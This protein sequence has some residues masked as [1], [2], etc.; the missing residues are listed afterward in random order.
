MQTTLIY[1]CNR[2]SKKKELQL[3]FMKAAEAREGLTMIMDP[4]LDDFFFFYVIL[5]ITGWKVIERVHKKNDPCQFLS[6]SRRIGKY[7]S[8]IF[9]R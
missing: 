7:Q 8:L 1:I 5:P 3:Y 2:F 4:M 9:M 6:F